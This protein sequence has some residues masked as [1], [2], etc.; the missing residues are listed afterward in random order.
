[1]AKTKQVKGRL[2]SIQYVHDPEAANEWMKLLME[3]GDD[4]T[5]ENEFAN[6]SQDM[7]D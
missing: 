5:D 4:D 3:M 2:T 6:E 1:M 7:S